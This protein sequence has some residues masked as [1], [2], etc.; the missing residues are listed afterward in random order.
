[1]FPL[2]YSQQ[3]L[4]SDWVPTDIDEEEGSAFRA[5]LLPTLDYMLRDS[6]LQF[7]DVNGHGVYVGG[8]VVLEGLS[9]ED[10]NRRRGILRGRDPKAQD[11]FAVCLADES[12]KEPMGNVMSV[13]SKNFHRDGA[14]MGLRTTNGGGRTLLDTPEQLRT[15]ILQ[16]LR[17]RATVVDVLNVIRGWPMNRVGAQFL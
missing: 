4:N 17:E 11:R 15:S 10:F 1:M 5:E 2:A 9:C 7:Q 16:N 6:S 14:A 12:K 3:F 13:K 8:S